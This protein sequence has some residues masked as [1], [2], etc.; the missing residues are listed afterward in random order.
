VETPSKRIEAALSPLHEREQDTTETMAK[1]SEVRNYDETLSWLREHQFDV[2]EAPGTKTNRVFLKK[3]NCS[4]AIEK[5]PDDGVKLF[6]YPGYLIGGEIAKLVN[7]GYQQ[8]LKT[9]KTEIAATADHLKALHDFTEELKEAVGKPSLY[10]ESLGTVSDAYL[11][12][13]VEGRDQP[14]TSRRKRPW[15]DLAGSGKSGK[16]A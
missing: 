1:K 9:T 7:K 10:N 3:Y 2:L 11:Y 8:V 13:R 4:A 15:E 12:D 6:A 16:R 5:A 14:D